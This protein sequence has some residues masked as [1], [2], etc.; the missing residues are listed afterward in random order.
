MSASS[1]FVFRCLTGTRPPPPSDCARTIGCGASVLG[2]RAGRVRCGG[3]SAARWALHIAR[4]GRGDRLRGLVGIV[5]SP[6]EQPLRDDGA[7]RP[8]EMA[9]S[10]GRG[11]VPAPPKLL[12]QVRAQLRLR[13]YSPRT[14]AAYV[15][16]IRRFILF[17]GKKHP[18]TLG[19][20]HV[21]VFLTHLATQE[22]VSASTQNQALNALDVPLFAGAESRSRG[23]GGLR[24][25]AQA[26]PP[27]GGA[28][29]RRGARGAR[30]A[31]GE[32]PAG[33]RAFST[34]PV[35]GC[36]NVWSCASR[37]SISSRRRS[38]CG[39]ARAAR[40]A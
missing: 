6:R 24:A 9:G 7:G 14:E 31:R 26:A 29:A 37:T 39:R 3:P 2:R 18:L 15:Q 1:V 22:G 33:W 17:H 25:R 12:D 40:I 32:L 16:W 21:A 8:L 34:G 20:R 35:S 28:V 10:D 5:A 36:S 13:H 11:T 23:A 27:A 30:A 4:G 19:T 38:G